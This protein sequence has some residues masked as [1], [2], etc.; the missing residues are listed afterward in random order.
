MSIV[1]L[2]VLSVQ[3]CISLMYPKRGKLISFKKVAVIIVSI[4][5]YTMLVALPPWFGWGDFVPETSGMT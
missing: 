5:A 2:S 3:R 4:W 1:T